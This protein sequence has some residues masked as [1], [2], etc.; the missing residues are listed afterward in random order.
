MLLKALTTSSDTANATQPCRSAPSARERTRATASAVDRP[1]RKP[2]WLSCSPGT[3]RDKCDSRRTATT[4][5]SSSPASSNGTTA[6]RWKASP[7][8]IPASAAS[9]NLGA[10]TPATSFHRWAGT[11]SGPGA[12]R[13]PILPTASTKSSSATLDSGLK[14]PAVSGGSSSGGWGSCSSSSVNLP[15]SSLVA[16][17]NKVPTT[18]SRNG[19][20]ILSVAGGANGRSLFNTIL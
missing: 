5:S 7:E 15:S 18:S 2:N 1:L 13:A 14:L 17:G 3:L 6:G 4:L 8:S 12:S 9:I 16:P 20:S 10:K 11:P 19:G